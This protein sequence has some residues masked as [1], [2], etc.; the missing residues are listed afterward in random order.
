MW[1]APGGIR[2]RQRWIGCGW[3]GWDLSITTLSAVGCFS[4]VS[5]RT[6]LLGI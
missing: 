6:L 3:I 2:S 4:K 1:L 5:Y